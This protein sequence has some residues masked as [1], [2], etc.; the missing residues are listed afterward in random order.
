VE[1]DFF[2]AEPEVTFGARLTDH[3]GL[4][5]GAGYRFTGFVDN[6]DDRLDGASGTISLQLRLP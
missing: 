6:L 5:I 3:L 1:E 4:N 2:L